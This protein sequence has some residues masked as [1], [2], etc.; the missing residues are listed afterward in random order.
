MNKF[1]DS[2]RQERVFTLC[3]EE[4]WSV[5]FSVK[6]DRYQCFFTLLSTVLRKPPHC[7]WRQL[8][9]TL[10]TLDGTPERFRFFFLFYFVLLLWVSETA[11]VEISLLPFSSTLFWKTLRNLSVPKEHFRRKYFLFL[12]FTKIREILIENCFSRFSKY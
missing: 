3:F 8:W 11:I 7:Q 4:L 1:L 2:A 6:R 10:D 9:L 5:F 12:Y